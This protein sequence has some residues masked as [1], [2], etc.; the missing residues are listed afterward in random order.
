MSHGFPDE[1]MD[2]SVL[3]VLIAVTRVSTSDKV[4]A[5]H[6]LKRERQAQLDR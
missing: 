4:V 5:G 1:Q 3:C 6:L 2:R